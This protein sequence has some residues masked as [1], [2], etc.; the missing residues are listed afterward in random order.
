MSEGPL[1]RAE[2]HE[3][4]QDDACD[5]GRH[6]DNRPCGPSATIFREI[7][8]DEE[9]YQSAHYELHEDR[10]VVEL[11]D[12]GEGFVVE[13][14]PPLSEPAVGLEIIRALADEVEVGPRAD[15]DGSRL[16]FVKRFR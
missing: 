4:A 5:R 9:T 6:G 12:E 14:V 1:A 10:L 11:T 16:R 3:A 7:D 2:R 13:A 8:P 15:G